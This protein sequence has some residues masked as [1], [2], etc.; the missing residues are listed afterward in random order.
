MRA[1]TTALG[2]LL[3]AAAPAA[4]QPAFVDAGGLHVVSERALDSRLLALTVSTSALSG[5]ANVRILLPAS[6]S[7]DPSRSYP[8][9]Y[10]F[11][12]TSGRASDWTTMGD[13]ERTTNGLPLIVVMPDIGLGGDGGGWCTNWAI[14]GAGGVPEWETFHVDQLI[15]WV[16]RNLR[17]VSARQGRAIF[18]LSQGGFCSMS[19]AARHP[20]LFAIAGSYSGADEIAY[21]RQAELLVGPV[22]DLTAVGLDGAPLDAF[23]GNPI[24]EQINWAA[25]D[26]ATL[27]ENLRAT[28][29][30]MYTGNG[31]SGP[32]DP[33]VPNPGAAAI[34]SG[35]NELNLLFHQRLV[36]LGIPSTYDDYG[37][38]THIWPYWTRDL[39]ESIGP[40]MADF[41]RPPA[42]PSQIS[43]TT[44]E[45][46][47][48]VYGWTVVMHRSV[49]EF[50]TL[51]HASAEGF[52]LAGSGSA[53]VLSPPVFAPNSDHTITLHGSALDLQAHA[54]ADAAGRL[55]LEVPLG[56]SNTIQADTLAA[57]L[58]GTRTY[59]TTVT[60]GSSTQSGSAACQSR[61]LVTVHLHV[62]RG[63]HTTGATV[64]INGQPRLER[65]SGSRLYVDLRGLPYGSYRVS[66]VVH[67]RRRGR[68]LTLRVS[69]TLH[70]CRPAT[71]TR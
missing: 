34:E 21:D 36:S 56:P 61:R 16:D 4:A 57:T 45:G 68:P 38:G 26:P 7:T 40:I 19:Y 8:V 55:R 50:S 58:V 49:K 30:F 46:S 11:H 37:P 39:R 52:A 42:T 6:Y 27:A 15:P 25:H 70:T 48:S 69:R 63:A 14:A 23:F 22:M 18:G 2:F 28:D 51:G 62:P 32:F 54:S 60:I 64:Q 41:A 24:T 53:S 31:Q 1:I 9:L 71:R 65:L 29:L 33:P 5:P 35:V 44:A 67:A 47:Y 12:G 59:T 13:A 3:I 10:L 66:A 43:Y 17:T 20:D